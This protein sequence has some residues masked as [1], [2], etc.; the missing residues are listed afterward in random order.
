MFAEHLSKWAKH[1][2]NSGNGSN[3]SNSNSTTI[4]IRTL[5]KMIVIWELELR[6]TRRDYT[7]LLIRAIQPI[8]WLIVFGS[9]F[10]YISQTSTLSIS[11][12]SS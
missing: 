9:T 10:S 8:L 5:S 3:N 7:D 11:N 12:S 1:S 6:K 4:I 2:A